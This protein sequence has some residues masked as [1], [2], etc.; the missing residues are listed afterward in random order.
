[1]YP[2]TYNPDEKDLERIELQK[3]QFKKRTYADADNKRYEKFERKL[4]KI[5]SVPALPESPKHVNPSLHE[6]WAALGRADPIEDKGRK[7]PFN[8]MNEQIMK[9]IKKGTLKR[10]TLSDEQREAY[11]FYLTLPDDCSE[12]GKCTV[13]GGRRKKRRTRKRCTPKRRS[14]SSRRA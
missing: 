12:H 7:Y 11:K 13:S 9:D 4:Q 14:K 2:R 10:V 8:V 3:V 6:L 5:E 1:M